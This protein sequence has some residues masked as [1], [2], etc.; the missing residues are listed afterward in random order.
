M[1]MVRAMGLIATC[2]NQYLEETL[3]RLTVKA[4][5]SL[6]KAILFINS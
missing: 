6:T 3:E 1:A 5:T 2:E 4:N